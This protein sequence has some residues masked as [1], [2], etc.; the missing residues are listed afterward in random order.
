ML[1]DY[2]C[3]WAQR[4]APH[5]LLLFFEDLKTELP[6]NVRRIANFLHLEPPLSEAEL[7]AVMEQSTHR[8]MSSSEMRP[9]F[10]VMPP[11]L[12][13]WVPGVPHTPNHLP[14]VPSIMCLLLCVL[15]RGGHRYMM[16]IFGVVNGTGYPRVG[17]V[18]RTGGKQGEGRQ[19]APDLR[20][21]LAE[22]WTTHVEPRTNLASYAEMLAQFRAERQQNGNGRLVT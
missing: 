13:R 3:F 21:K 7:A 17:V 20:G 10:N 14:C 5:M 18:R 16:K 12:K 9:R 15:A 11:R 2:A 4:H 1:D 8:F 6:P 22:L 19:L